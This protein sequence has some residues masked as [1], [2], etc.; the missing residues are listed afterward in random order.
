MSGI[1]TN[2]ANIDV[3]LSAVMMDDESVKNCILCCQPCD[4]LEKAIEVVNWENVNVKASKWKGLD[5]YSNAYDSVDWKECSVGL[6]W[7]TSS[8]LVVN[9]CN[10]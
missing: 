2:T 4:Q 1:K 9:P 7:H 10:S 3:D 6:V 8:L 5:K